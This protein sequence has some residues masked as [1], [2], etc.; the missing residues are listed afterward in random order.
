[1]LLQC[2]SQYDSEFGKLSSC[3]WTGKGQCSFQSQRKTMPKN[4]Q[5]LPYS[6]AHFT[7]YDF[8]GRNDAKAET[9]VLWPPHVKNWL[10]GKD[11]C[12]EGLGKGGEGDDRGWDGWMAS[13]TRWTWV[14]V[15]SGSWSWTGRPG[16]LWFMGSQ[17][18]GHDWATERLNWTELRVSGK[19]VMNHNQGRT[20]RRAGRVGMEAEGSRAPFSTQHKWRISSFSFGK[21]I[22]DRVF[23]LW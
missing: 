22:T 17:R 9:P 16:V 11:W 23:V 12:W 19:D 3:H 10:I 1:M 13:P 6:C 18:V 14:W 8:F 5:K 4:V 20:L 7:C 2:C 15:N 21:H